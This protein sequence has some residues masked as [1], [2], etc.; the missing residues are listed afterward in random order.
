MVDQILSV[1]YLIQF[2][3]IIL[4]LVGLFYVAKVIRIIRI[5]DLDVIKAKVFLNDTFLLKLM[6]LLI[7]ACILFIFFAIA[8]TLCLIYGNNCIVLGIQVTQWIKKSV[9]IGLLLCTIITSQLWYS[10][11][12][13]KTKS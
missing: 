7:I 11:L 10:T 2:A 13:A 6:Y 1:L 9:L 8:E 5:T 12:V 4:A 3:T